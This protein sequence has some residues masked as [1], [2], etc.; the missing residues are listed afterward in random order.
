MPLT[1]VV[2]WGFCLFCFVLLFFFWGGG[3]GVV[4]FFFLG[5]SVCGVVHIKDPL[6]L[7]GMSSPCTG[8]SGFPLSL[9]KWSFTICITLHNHK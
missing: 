1:S 6:L 2:C 8:G 5:G 7:I 9:S 4:G 3:G